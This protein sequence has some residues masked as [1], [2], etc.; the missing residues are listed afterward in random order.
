[1]RFTISLSLVVLG[2][3]L[4]GCDGETSSSSSTGG[5]GAATSSGGGQGGAGAA[6]SSGGTGGAVSEGDVPAE[7]D[8]LFAYLKAGEYKSFASESAAHPSS[9]PHSGDVRVF[10]N[11]LLDASLAAGNTAHPRG[12]ACVKELGVKSGAPAGWA[13]FVKTEDDSQG[14]DGFYWYEI[15][16]TVDGSNPPFAGQGEAICK[17]CHGSGGVDFYLSAYPLQ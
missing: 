5:S 9:G 13:V 16:N 4:S 10:V 14:G 17:N 11:P 8:A 6:T 7:Q 2:C 1:M 15:L 12:A 3:L